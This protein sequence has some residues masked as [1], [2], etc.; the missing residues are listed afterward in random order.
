[1]IL[2]HIK[3]E[4][5]YASLISDFAALMQGMRLQNKSALT[6]P[7][8]ACLFAGFVMLSPALVL[9]VNHPQA[10]RGAPSLVPGKMPLPLEKASVYLE[11]KL[12]IRNSEWVAGPVKSMP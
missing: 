3:I 1:M 4:E 2:P 6:V 11:Q 10:D 8:M 5:N 9:F 7:V 12:G